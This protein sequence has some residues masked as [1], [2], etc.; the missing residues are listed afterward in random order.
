MLLS[1]DNNMIGGS[2]QEVQDY[3]LRLH[4]AHPARYV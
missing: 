4:G 2:S 3:A 1:T